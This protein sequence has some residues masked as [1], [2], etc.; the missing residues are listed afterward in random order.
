MSF[1]NMLEILKEKDKEKIVFVKLGPFY[2][3]T[4]KDAVFLNKMYLFQK[5]SL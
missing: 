1:S 3:A 5:G 4:G 2:V